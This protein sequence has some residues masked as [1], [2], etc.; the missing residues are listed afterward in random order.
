MDNRLNVA[1]DI[2]AVEADVERAHRGTLALDLLDLGREA[3]GEGLSAA[4][5]ANHL[6]VLRALVVLDDFVSDARDGTL[7]GLLVH[8]DGLEPWLSHGTPFK[9]KDARTDV[10]RHETSHDGRPCV[11]VGRMRWPCGLP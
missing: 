1:H 7:H 2:V 10:S 6:D 3:V 8:D 9:K 11:W 5:D 4:N